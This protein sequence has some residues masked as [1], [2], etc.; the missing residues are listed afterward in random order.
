MSK[1]G[2]QGGVLEGK[3]NSTTI[4]AFSRCIQSNTSSYN[5]QITD[6]TKMDGTTL[7]LNR[8][9][10]HLEW[11]YIHRSSFNFI[12]IVASILVWQENQHLEGAGRRLNL[13]NQDTTPSPPPPVPQGVVQE[14]EGERRR[15][16][17]SSKL[18]IAAVTKAMTLLRQR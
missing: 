16:T 7:F 6:R 15:R 8:V 4:A 1:I 9:S 12:L 14:P 3:F 5:V 11:F 10:L 17:R 13:N 18:M 2:K